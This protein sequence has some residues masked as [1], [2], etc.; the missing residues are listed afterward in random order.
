MLLTMGHISLRFNLTPCL[1]A[2]PLN[3]PLVRL[4]TEALLPELL[5]V[6]VA[7]PTLQEARGGGS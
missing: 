6:T 4:S 5:M 7:H 1:R 3:R 2:R